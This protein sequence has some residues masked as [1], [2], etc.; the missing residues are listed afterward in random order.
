MSVDDQFTKSL[1]HFDGANASTIFTDESGK[2]WTRTG[3]NPRGRNRCVV[4][5][6]NPGISSQNSF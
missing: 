3:Q 1:L 2:I 6:L 4:G 5:G